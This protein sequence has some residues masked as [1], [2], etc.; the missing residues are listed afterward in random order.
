MPDRGIS[1]LLF[2]ET[3]VAKIYCYRVNILYD[4]GC[5]KGKGHG[6]QQ[7]TD[8]TEPSQCTLCCEMHIPDISIHFLNG[9]SYEKSPTVSL[10]ELKKT[11]ISVLDTLS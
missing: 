4:V 10:I 9:L 11:H 5:R 3:L 6:Q 8:C 1:P 2:H 7:T